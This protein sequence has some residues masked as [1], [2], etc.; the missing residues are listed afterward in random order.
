MKRLEIAGI[1]TAAGCAFLERRLQAALRPC[2][3]A[4]LNSPLIVV[5]AEASDETTIRAH[6]LVGGRR[7]DVPCR[8]DDFEPVPR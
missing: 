1:F 5:E 2:V 3:P 6:K 7:C 8:A 4:T